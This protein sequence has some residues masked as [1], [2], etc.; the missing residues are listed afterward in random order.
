MSQNIYC[1]PK[2]F[3]EDFGIVEDISGNINI[4][5]NSQITSMSVTIEGID[6]SQSALMNKRVKFF[7]NHGSIDT[8]PYFMGL[9][10]DVQP[11]DTK[12]NL[13]AYDVRCLLGGEY[14][15]NII[16]D[17]FNNYDG[18]TLSGFLVKYINENIND[19]KEYI[20]TSRINDTNPPISMSGYRGENIK[21]YSVCLELLQMATDESD[22]YDTF[23]YEIGVKYTSNSSQIVFIKEKSLTSLPSLHMSYGDGIKSYNYKKIKIPN[24]TRQE[25]ILV[26]FGSTN[27]VRVTRDVTTHMAAQ[28]FR[29]TG[30]DMISRAPIAKE[31]LKALVKAR[32]EKYTITINATKGHYVD[33]GSIIYLNVDEEINGPHRL[34]S[35]TVNFSRD[36]IDLSLGLEAKPNT[37]YNYA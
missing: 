16:L 30:S 13:T 5:G 2:I 15:D 9:I 18:F 33:L 25:E 29:N 35:K 36:G 11:S 37:L 32:Q 28:N 31:L 27:T 26:D 7:L 3:I 24:R 12:I 22:I 10:K 21:P 4:S 1:N 14:A 6:L 19:K 17:G 20:D 23:Q 34:V 8:V